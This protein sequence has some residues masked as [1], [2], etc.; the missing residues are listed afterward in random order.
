MSYLDPE[1]GLVEADQ[2]DECRSCGQ[3]T[4]T[5]D[6]ISHICKPCYEREQ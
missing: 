3:P 1:D 4:R 6:Y 2:E 5:T